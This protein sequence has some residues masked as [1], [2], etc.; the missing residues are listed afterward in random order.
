M[1]IGDYVRISKDKYLFEKGYTHT[2]RR[3]IFVIHKILYEDPIKIII[4]D[5]NGEEIDGKFYKE[6]IQKIYLK[7]EDIKKKSFKIEKILK[8]RKNKNK[9]EDIFVK[10]LGY[11]NSFNSWVLAKDRI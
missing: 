9:T 10:W 6:E 11:P 1:N 5:L 3:E 7:D 8:T 2:W 4:K